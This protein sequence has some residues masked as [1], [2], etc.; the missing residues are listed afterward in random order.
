MPKI[1][2]VPASKPTELKNSPPRVDIVL[3]QA[4]VGVKF[5]RQL[6]KMMAEIKPHL[7]G[8]IHHNLSLTSWQYLNQDIVGQIAPYAEELFRLLPAESALRETE[9]DML[10]RCSQVATGADVRLILGA[11]LDL[12][13]MLKVEDRENYI[14]GLAALLEFETEMEGHSATAVASALHKAIVEQKFLPDPAELIPQI[15]VH[16]RRIEHALHILSGLIEVRGAADEA[17]INAGWS[18]EKLGIEVADD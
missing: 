2:V 13:P 5:C 17:L 1:N 10:E 7:P 15:A 6:S 9:A 3:R 11:F 18:L 12:K 4:L 16:Q 8:T 14:I